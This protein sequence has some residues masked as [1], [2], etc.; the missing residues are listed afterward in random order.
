[1]GE[2]ALV[3]VDLLDRSLAVS[4]ALIAVWSM[5]RAIAASR[6][7]MVDENERLLKSIERLVDVVY[8]RCL[9]DDET[10]S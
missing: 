10:E 5:G 6:Q 3:W 9:S 8:R 7:A 2:D 1:M 4:V